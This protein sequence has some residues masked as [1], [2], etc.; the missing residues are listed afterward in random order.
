MEWTSKGLPSKIYYKPNLSGYDFLKKYYIHFE[1]DTDHNDPKSVLCRAMF[2]HDNWGT[3]HGTDFFYLYFPN[4]NGSS[5]SFLLHDGGEGTGSSYNSQ[6]KIPY[7]T[8]TFYLYKAWNAD[9][10]TL[11]ECYIFCQ[12]RE[13]TLGKFSIT[14]FNG[15]RKNWKYKISTNTSFYDGWTPAGI[16]SPT[17]TSIVDNGDNRAI[18]SGTAPGTATYS[19]TYPFPNTVESVLWYTTHEPN[20]EGNKR[21]SIKLN[22]GEFNEVVSMIDKPDTGTTLV[23]VDAFVESDPKYGDNK[24]VNITDKNIKYWEAPSDQK[25]PEI[26]P[27]RNSKEISKITPKCTIRCQ[28][29]MATPGNSNSSDLKYNGCSFYFLIKRSGTSVWETYGDGVGDND[30]KYIDIF[31]E[32]KTTPLKTRYNSPGFVCYKVPDYNKFY[33]DIDSETY[34]LQK[35][36]VIQVVIQPWTTNVNRSDI[37]HYWVGLSKP[38]K[39]STVESAGIVN[40]KQSANSWS[41]GQVYIK[42]VSGWLEA[43]SVYI[44]DSSDWK[45]SI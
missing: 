43:D 36:D 39:E 37:R 3:G 14:L 26:K 10:F 32:D 19:E 12:G 31:Y 21:K 45:E 27:M 11:P 40:I 5:R 16:S 33:I 41:E 29:E 35:E 6:R 23:E 42:T 1:I 25:Q 15:S 17:L 38:S 7:Y 18:I 4:L 13:G 44:K 24:A 20:V 28:W 2:G 8:D 30:W 22:P 34:N 9:Y